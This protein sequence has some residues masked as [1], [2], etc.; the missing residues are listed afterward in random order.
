MINKKAFVRKTKKKII[1]LSA[2]KHK[3]QNQPYR[4]AAHQGTTSSH[5]IPAILPHG[6]NN[7]SVAKPSTDQTWPEYY[8]RQCPRPRSLAT[9]RDGH[10]HRS[11]RTQCIGRKHRSGHTQL[12]I[13]GN[14]ALTSFL[15]INRETHPGTKQQTKPTPHN[16][17]PNNNECNNL[18]RRR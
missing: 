15:S 4:P 2:K 11:G 3:I 17:Q 10:T 16:N 12:S 8:L 14:M 9:R 7:E 1:S 6:W 13:F 18:Q 5:P